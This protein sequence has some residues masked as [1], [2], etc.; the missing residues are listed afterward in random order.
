VSDH[1]AYFGDWFATACE[2]AGAP[3]PVGLDSISFVPELLGQTARQSRHEFLYWEF[4]EGGFKQAALLD[5]RWKGIR[6]DRRE[7]PITLYDLRS[8]P[9]ETNDVAASHPDLVA[10]LH[11]YLG[12]AR[13]P[14]PEWEP[15]WR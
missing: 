3:V 10:R 12:R 15:R 8:D 1:V 9:G 4:H 11:D 6:A 2:L 5:G 13:T 14:S 7:A